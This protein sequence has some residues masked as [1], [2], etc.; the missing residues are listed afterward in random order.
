M[1][2]IYIEMVN[3]SI[4]MTIL[5]GGFL[6]CKQVVWPS[7]VC[8]VKVMGRLGRG[9]GDSVPD[10]T[11]GPGQMNLSSPA[12]PEEKL[13]LKLKLEQNEGFEVKVK[14]KEEKKDVDVDAVKKEGQF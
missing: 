11:S 12:P 3:I 9:S 8:L 13:E 7:L 5:A 14:V 2:E 1:I 4:N 6:V 10:P